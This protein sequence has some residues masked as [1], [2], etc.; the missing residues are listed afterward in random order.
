MST[1]Y[2]YD[3]Q[4]QYFPFFVL[5]IAGLFTLPTTYSLLRPS[6]GMKEYFRNVR[7]WL[8]KSL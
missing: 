3:E 2:N 5:T 8:M 6:K 7:H 4:G 1:D